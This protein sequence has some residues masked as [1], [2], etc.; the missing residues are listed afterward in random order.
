VYA[1]KGA[2]ELK[3]RMSGNDPLYMVYDFDPR[4]TSIET[5]M[6]FYDEFAIFMP[7]VKQKK[8]G[9]GKLTKKAYKQI[10]I[11]HRKVYNMREQLRWWK[12]AE[13]PMRHFFDSDEFV[14]RLFPLKPSAYSHWQDKV[15]NARKKKKAEEYVFFVRANK[16]VKGK[17]FRAKFELL[18]KADNED[19]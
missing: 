6:G 10:L 19:F 12:N 4:E 14:E 13:H 16:Q 18:K 7:D 5:W 15:L 11:D 17:G 9:L 2:L 3:D 8:R 1:K